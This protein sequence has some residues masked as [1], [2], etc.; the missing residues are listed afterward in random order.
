MQPAFGS[1]A[2]RNLPDVDHTMRTLFVILYLLPYGL[3]AQQFR[4]QGSASQTGPLS[5][6]ITDEANSQAGMITNYYP[7]TLSQNF[8]ISFELNFGT[9]NDNGADGMAFVLSN[10]CTPQ[11]SV[12]Q[13]LG[14]SNIP[15]SLIVDFDTYFNAAD[16]LNDLNNDHTGIYA[17]GQLKRSGNVMDG[18]PVP[19]CLLPNCANVET[20]EWYPVTI[21]WTYISA[22]EQKLQM[23]FNG[24]L[25]VSSTRNHIAERFNNNP[26]VF[27]SLAGSTGF[28]NNLQQFRISSGNNNIIACEGGKFL[29]K[30]PGLGSNYSWTGGSASTFDTAWFP[31]TVNQ[32]LT[33]LYRDYC[34]EQRSVDFQVEVRSN[35]RVS[36]TND[37]FCSSIP[38]RVTAVPETNGNYSFIW[39]VPSGFTNPG[40]IPS[41]TSSQTGTYTVLIRDTISNCSSPVA[42]TTVTLA[43]ADRPQFN[44]LPAVCRGSVLPSL[45]TTSING[46]AGSW[47][48]ALN[49]DTTTVYTF[50][51]AP[52]VCAYTEK[53]SGVIL[54][55]PAFVHFRDTFLCTGLPLL[56]KPTVS[57][58]GLSFRW[59]DG[60]SDSFYRVVQPGLYTLT[61]ANNCGNA[62]RTVLVSERTC[63]V[64]IP[65][66][67]TPNDDGLNDVFRISGNDLVTD[68]TL[69]VYNRWGKLVFS[70][71]HP[72]TG[73]DGMINGQKQP[74]GIYVYRVRYTML[75]SGEKAERKGTFSLLR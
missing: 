25:R 33:C 17:D 18:L 15:N 55:P 58:T 54:Q 29:L 3:F 70:T 71:T 13:G 61:I 60:S 74:P 52:G 56:L 28:Y 21:E 45:P 32:T 30:A 57:G 49:P 35:P 1:K 59:Q 10:V 37:G 19:V 23:Y 12:G 62:T 39:T 40:S 66:S 16:S 2:C 46:I 53:L 44:P 43:P 6:T 5:Y 31:A 8:K 7:V 42:Q 68:F 48:P 34:G 26:V 11:L 14:V 65:S 9:K 51:P 36:V 67:F 4:L 72:R 47:T 38:A 63:N 20:G 75:Q 24:V 73:W 27:W 41:F 22:A 50:T 69:E 64:Y